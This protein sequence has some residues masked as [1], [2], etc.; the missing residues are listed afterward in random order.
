MNINTPI[1][2]PDWHLLTSFSAAES[3]ELLRGWLIDKN[4]LTARLK[5]LCDDNLSI[6]VVSQQIQIPR[7]SEIQ[8]FP[9]QR[10]KRFFVRDVILIGSGNP[11]V[12]ARSILR[13]ETISGELSSLRQLGANP[14]GAWLFSQPSL[15]RGVMQIAM[16]Q[17]EHVPAL[18]PILA[19]DSMWGRRS[20]FFVLG[21]P[22]LVTEIFLPRFKSDLEK[23]I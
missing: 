5:K 22:I 8:L 2:E 11:W 12:Y 4:S 13:E 9:V 21:E 10:G 3:P 18:D 20:M 6:D 1:S 15:H 23:L 7:P 17:A 16:V 14:L 19:S